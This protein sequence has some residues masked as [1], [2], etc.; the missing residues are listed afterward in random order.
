MM[1][2]INI[3]KD[4]DSRREIARMAYPKKSVRKMEVEPVITQTD[5]EGKETM[6]ETADPVY[7]LRTENNKK[8]TGRREAKGNL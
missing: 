6:R 7:S 5:D 3:Q 2:K 1:K 4:V 8:K